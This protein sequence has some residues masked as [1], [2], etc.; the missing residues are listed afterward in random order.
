[1]H[2]TQRPRHPHQ[3]SSQETHCQQHINTR[4]TCQHWTQ[5]SVA[6][7]EV[8]NECLLGCQV[9]GRVSAF[10]S[11]NFSIHFKVQFIGFLAYAFGARLLVWGFVLF[12]VLIFFFSSCLEWV[13]QS[14]IKLSSRHWWWPQRLRLNW[15]FWTLD[16]GLCHLHY[17]ICFLL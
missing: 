4:P 6:E 1:M 10:S 7:V 8:I 5:L 3:E 16:G 12:F 17:L 15:P 11:W 2:M 9:D 14:L 13:V